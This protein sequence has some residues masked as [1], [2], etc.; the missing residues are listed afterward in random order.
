MIRLISLNSKKNELLFAL[1]RW[2]LDGLAVMPGFHG[3]VKTNSRTP[4]AEVSHHVTRVC[5]RV[6]V[7]SVDFVCNEEKN[8][9]R[10]SHVVAETPG[11]LSMLP[12]IS[13]SSTAVIIPPACQT[14]H[15]SRPIGRPTHDV[16]NA[17]ACILD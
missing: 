16:L 14:V 8:C 7:F 15:I 4:I 3:M 2:V 1:G 10:Q 9:C 17:L 6:C 11:A 13:P 5:V 12:L